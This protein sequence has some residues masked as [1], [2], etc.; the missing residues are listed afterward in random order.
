MASVFADPERMSRFFSA[1]STLSAAESLDEFL[2][3]VVH[4]ARSLAD[5]DAATLEILDGEL[6]HRLIST[7]RRGR[8]GKVALERELNVVERPYGILRLTTTRPR[9]TPQEEALV[10]LL[11]LYVEVGIEKASLR[12]REDVLDRVRALLGDELDATA[13]STARDIGDVRIDLARYQVTVAGSPVHLTPSEFRLLELLTE[14]PGRAYM[15]HE[16]VDRL[17]EG[18]Y[19]GSS[20]VADAHVARLRR[21][22]ERDPRH[23]ERLQHVR[24][25]GYRFV[26]VG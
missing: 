14:D 10:D 22:I 16:I 6:P 26:P 9:F 18:D 5:A 20:R 11:G 7:G 4:A 2:R 1:A 21:K 13:T 17:W 24:G 23:P 19:S 15:R 25:V 3:R 8:G 12:A